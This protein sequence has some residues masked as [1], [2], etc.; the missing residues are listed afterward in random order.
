MAKQSANIASVSLPEW[1]LAI[2]SRRHCRRWWVLN[3]LS[4]LPLRTRRHYWHSWHTSPWVVCQPRK[5]R[6]SLAMWT[7]RWEWVSLLWL[8][9]RSNG[10]AASGSPL[11]SNVR[12]NHV[13]PPYISNYWVACFIS[14]SLV[15][16]IRIGRSWA[17]TSCS[18]LIFINLHH[19]WVGFINWVLLCCG[20]C[21]KACYLLINNSLPSHA[22][23]GFTACLCY[24]FRNCKWCIVYY[25]YLFSYFHLYRLA[26]SRLRVV[27]L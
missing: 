16:I 5:R 12:A 19:S 18:F 13:H 4:R 11:T 23:V 3:D 22:F 27:R 17:F 14:P 6:R 24:I 1:W 10:P 15:G 21:S 26:S 2:L 9:L 25:Y 7:V 20:F 8:T